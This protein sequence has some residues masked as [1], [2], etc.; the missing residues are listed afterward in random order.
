MTNERVQDRRQP[1]RWNRVRG[2]IAL[3]LVVLVL[4]AGF[5]PEGR[6][7]ATLPIT[8][9]QLRGVGPAATL[10]AAV[11]H[12]S[13]GHPA[14]ALPMLRDVVEADSEYV[15]SEHG[16][17][18]Y[19][20]GRAYGQT[21]RSERARRAWA[22][23][24]AAL[25]PTT[26]GPRL[27]DAYLQSLTPQSLPSQRLNAV[28]VYT[29]F[30]GG[31]G[32][33]R[34]D[35]ERAL[36]RRHVAQLAPM[37]GDDTF[38]RVVEQPRTADPETWTFHSEAGA[39]L[40]AW[41]R[42]HDPLPATPENERLEEHLT[43]WV[44]AEA[45]YTCAE[46]VSGLD[47]RG[48]ASL[49]YGEPYRTHDIDFADGDFFRDVYRFGVAVTSSDFPENEF[50]VY[51]NID[52][53]GYYLF[54]REPGECYT[55]GTTEDLIPSHLRQYRGSSERGLNIAYSA[56][57][58]L[59]H[60]YERLAL[61]H[62]DFSSRYA[63]VAAYADWQDMQ[64]S[65][66]RAEERTGVEW[67]SSV[68]SVTVGA[69][70]GQ[71]R[72]VSKD[73]LFGIEFPTQFVESLVTRGNQ[74]DRA[75]ARRRKQAMPRQHTQMLSQ[76]EPLP[77]AVRTARFLRPNGTT[78]SRVY[79]GLRTNDLQAE[80]G[81]S[82]SMRDAVISFTGVR[83]DTAYRPQQTLQRQHVVRSEHLAERQLVIA[84]PIELG[85]ATE[86]YHLALQWDH[87]DAV[88]RGA[89]VHM[90]AQRHRATARADSLQ[91]LQADG[92]TLEV[93]DVQLMT[94]RPSAAALSPDPTADAVPYPFS[95][96]TADTPLLLY[97]EVYH[98]TFTPDD[99]TR[100]TVAY[101]VEQ[102]TKR[103]WTRFIRGR[104]TQRTTT[105]TIR[106]GSSR[107]TDE[108]IELD[109]AA[110]DREKPQDIRVTVRI[111]DEVTGQSVE[112]D[113]TFVLD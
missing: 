95:T 113:V 30:L 47:D 52:D 64:A 76:V 68:Q 90:R 77:V 45:S 51:T 50:W 66:Q 17:A 78:Y 84:P 6:A 101:E 2:R 27:A 107:R 112:R 15:S 54:T 62:A 71:T 93:S 40:Q 100:Y 72:T 61:F 44:A 57:V 70:V 55:I 23:G 89:S 32:A 85:G 34:S 7:Q 29:H 96:I 87:N 1:E 39:V 109:L 86:P 43:R 16:A 74:E 102:K 60:V 63:D 92:S 58:T 26:V 88:T 67:N 10:E 79:W 37:L 20:L 21:G 56:L 111:T 73:P 4:G 25:G 59:H 22:D 108:F 14:Q 110:L 12:L 38:G 8:D 99:R 83:H 48:V 103:G 18:A 35:A 36:Y 42:G 5:A 13:T 105:E 28:A 53:A 80:K 11:H 49:R 75:A 41:W 98:L 97:L 91:P 82:T 94:P 33:A 46:R 3:A 9:V 65:I 81:D 69:G 19:W 104:D 24:V 106:E 31:V